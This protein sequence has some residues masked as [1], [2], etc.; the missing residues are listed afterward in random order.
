[1]QN[2]LPLI[3][4]AHGP[5]TR[6]IINELIKLFNGMGYTYNEA[7]QKARDV[8]DEAQKKSSDVLNEA[9]RVNAMNVSV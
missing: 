7:L 1:M 2:K 6:N 9:K 3:N 8:L 4:S 5:E